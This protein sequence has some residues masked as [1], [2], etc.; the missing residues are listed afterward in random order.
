ML[1]SFRFA[2]Y[3][4]F[5]RS[6]GK[7]NAASECTEL[8]IRSFIDGAS[9]SASPSAY[10]RQLSK[11][12]DVKV[13]AVDLGALSTQIGRFHVVAVHQQFELFLREFRAEHPKSNWDKEEGDDL[14]KATLKNI[15][16]GY[17]RTA[18]LLGRLEVDVADYYRHVRNRFVH[19]MEE[20]ARMPVDAKE[21]RGRVGESDEYNRLAAPNAY[22]AIR[23]DDF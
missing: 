9:T 20:K 3:R 1:T 16:D 12:Y 22:D 23:F 17:A 2:S 18:S 19:A 21:L 8:A 15:G 5:K 11:D 14:L 13:D 6:L 10:I 7:I 4:D